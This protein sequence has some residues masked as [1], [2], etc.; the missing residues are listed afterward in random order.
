VT[1][2]ASAPVAAVA[3]VASVAV[4]ARPVSLAGSRLLAVDPSLAGLL[5]DGGLRR[6]S[7]VMVAGRRQGATSLILGLLSAA[8]AGGSWCGIVGIPDLGLVA[9]AAA[10]LDLGRVAIVAEVAP[11]QWATVVSVLVDAVD[12]VVTSPP[13]HLRLGD[14]RRLMTRVRERA[15][16]L[17]ANGSWPE[18]A[19][20]RVTVQQARWV[21]PGAGDGHLE[22][23]QIDVVTGGRGA[24]SRSRQVTLWLPGMAYAGADLEA[25]AAD[26]AMLGHVATAG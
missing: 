7:V 21:G 15:S 18:G 25:G 14:A 4:Q 22:G 1:S 10:G 20:V 24:A 6:G 16:V 23:R 9:A 17:I 19:D 8:S 26:E 11:A 5:P 2:V 13:P 12:V 3:S